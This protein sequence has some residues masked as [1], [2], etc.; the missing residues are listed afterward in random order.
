MADTWIEPAPHRLEQHVRMLAVLSVALGA[1]FLLLAV[2][3][4]MGTTFMVELFA[5]ES[6]DPETVR[7][8]L[9]GLGTGLLALFL[10]IAGPAIYG[11]LMLARGRR[12]GR[13]LVFVIAVPALLNFPVGTAFGAYAIYVLTR[14][15]VG[16]VLA[17]RKEAVAQK[18]AAEAA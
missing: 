16:Q 1:F 3:F 10:I 6:A 17:A 11:G 9:T 7:G 12:R 4:L 2:L 13:T 18:H 8:W 14:P 5:D 15:G